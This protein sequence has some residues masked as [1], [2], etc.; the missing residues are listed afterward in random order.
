MQLYSAD[1]A[2]AKVVETPRSSSCCAPRRRLQDRPSATLS[3]ARAR[4]AELPAAA[5]AHRRGDDLVVKTNALM[6]LNQLIQ[7]APD[8]KAKERLLLKLSRRLGVDRLLSSQLHLQEPDFR[9]QLRVYQQVA[10][11]QIPP[12]GAGRPLPPQVPADGRRAA[13]GARGLQVRDEATDGED[14]CASW[15]MREAARLADAQGASRRS[16]R[17]RRASSASSA[18]CRRDRARRRAGSEFSRARADVRRCRTSRS[19]GDEVAAAA[20]A[21][22]DLQARLTRE[23]SGWR[24][25]Y[26]PV[27][28]GDARAAAAAAAAAAVAAAGL[29]AV[30]AA[31]RRAAALSG[32][33][34]S[35]RG[36]GGGR[37]V[38][39]D[40]TSSARGGAAPP[41]PPPPPGAP[42]AP[43]PGAPV[44]PK[45]KPTKPPV[46]PSVKM[47]GGTGSECCSTCKSAR[48][49]RRS[50]LHAV[51]GR[52]RARIRR[53]RARG[54]ILAEDVGEPR[55][56][57][58]EGGGRAP[59]ARE[60]ARPQAVA[61][62][63][64]HDV[65][66]PP[67]ND[68]KAAIVNLDEATLSREQ[69]E[70][71]RQNMP[72]PEEMAE[73]TK[74]DGPTKWDKPETFLKTIMRI[75]KVRVR[76]RCWA[77]KMGFSEKAEELE[78][79]PRRSPR[80]SRRCAVQGPPPHPG[81]AAQAGNHMNG[82]TNKGQA[83][84]FVLDD[85]PKMSVVK[86]N[87][88]RHSLLEHAATVL[89][90][91]SSPTTPAPRA[92]PK[93]LT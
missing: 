81:H 45:P 9:Q 10:G 38:A 6:L 41:P 77:I 29:A 90:A 14:A 60:G 22:V 51:G 62:G 33:G 7:S 34:P 49:A 79:L 15:N 36:G 58:R 31:A 50:W 42:G 20:G 67:V 68:V 40:G 83:D 72:T 18:L 55:R 37:A 27:L 70:M 84:G 76:L 11:M 86:D 85:L 5:R 25:A 16:R 4:R 2:T 54:V 89:H 88:N 12:R 19:V 17:P 35:P 21:P 43:P 24:R 8:R 28:V 82:G 47:K 71:I 63:G 23:A 3:V 44:S 56:Q 57:R 91:S 59:A 69:L 93:S 52:R 46:Q 53:R 87:A 61:G 80:R 74:L 48:S 26:G 66:L 39:A 13:G 92:S 73:I 65:S 1:D 75:P 78:V 32:G 64:D 30:A